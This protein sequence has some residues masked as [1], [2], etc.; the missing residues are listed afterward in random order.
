MRP[1]APHRL[2]SLLAF[3]VAAVTVPAHAAT[4][5]MQGV[6]RTQAGGPVADSDYVLL[7]KLYDKQAAP[8]FVW[9]DTLTGV[10][11]KDGFFTAELGTTL[12]KALADDLL[13]SGKPLWL[14]VQVG[15]D[16]EL[17]RTLLGSVPKA[18]Y[19]HTAGNGAF[20]YAASTKPAGP[21]T[22][23]ACTG[24]VKGE[25]LAD[26]AV[27]S[28]K[29]AFSYAGSDS[30]G[31]AATLAVLANSAKEAD[32]ATKADS[33]KAAEAANVAAVADEAKALTC[34]GCIAMGHLDKSVVAGFV[35]TAGGK[36]TG[37]LAVDGKLSLGA[38]VVS[39]GRFEGVAV[40]ATA[41][42]LADL[43]R[44]ALDT[45]TKRLWLCDGD[46]WQRL[47]V[48]SEVCA[49][50]ATVAC[51]KPVMNACGD[52]GC[53]GATGS[54]CPAG[55]VCGASGQCA[56]PGESKDAAVASCKALLAQVPDAKSGVYW[57]DP[58]GAQGAGAPFQTVCDMTS[59]GGGWTLAMKSTT[60]NGD[61]YYDAAVWTKAGTLNETDLDVAKGKNAKYASF[62]AMPVTAILLTVGTVTKVFTLTDAAKGKT[63][64]Q[65]TSAAPD[66]TVET[67]ENIAGNCH[68]PQSFWGLTADG[69]ECYV[70]HNVGFDFDTYPGSGSISRIGFGLSQEYPCDH[71][72]TA[73]GFGLK[74]RGSDGD[75]L[76]SGRLQ[77]SLETN[78]FAPGAVWVR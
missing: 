54:L 73:E 45:E 37:E 77:W 4:L 72:G 12:G 61:L 51:G 1:P 43:G 70:C 16:P 76:G 30:K 17:P 31:G 49:A 41:C 32:H 44:V 35:S 53:G 68:K 6:L 11:L 33:A 13:T 25:A 20:P 59:N 28:N 7:V 57:L 50:P 29:V 21:A 26:G 66:K 75:Q 47:V 46:K 34:S 52:A 18:W 62:D 58:D 36:I 55:Q 9:E 78:Y 8:L 5:A 15:S 10:K 71:N 69:H 67:V 42:K 14:G 27:G 40:K 64:L 63:L 65:L 38:S 3:V 23:L 39:G 24:C 60:D 56:G 2:L 22:D 19:A 48:C 74:D